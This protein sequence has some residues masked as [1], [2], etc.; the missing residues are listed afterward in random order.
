MLN[1]VLPLLALLLNVPNLNLPS[2]LLM[3]VSLLN[4]MLLV[5]NELNQWLL[6][7]YLNPLG[8]ELQLDMLTLARDALGYLLFFKHDLNRVIKVDIYR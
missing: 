4:L 8:N 5:R 3:V 6:D 1:K 7:L 2:L